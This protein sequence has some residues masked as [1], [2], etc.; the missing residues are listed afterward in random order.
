MWEIII[1]LAAVVTGA[2]AVF[3]IIKRQAKGGAA[4]C[5]RG[6]PY[7]DEPSRCAPPAGAGD[8]PPDC[9][10]VDNGK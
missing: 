4:A 9:P 8:L 10:A 6:C 7:G 2:V 5:C 3:L 1:V